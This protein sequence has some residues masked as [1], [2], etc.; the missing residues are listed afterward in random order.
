[1]SMIK[2]QEKL[3]QE[4]DDTYTTIDEVKASLTSTISDN[5]TMVDKHK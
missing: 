3:K 2:L 5:K 4:R 1:M